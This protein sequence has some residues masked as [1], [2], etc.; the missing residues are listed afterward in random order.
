MTLVSEVPSEITVGAQ[1]I[2]VNAFSFTLGIKNG[3]FDNAKS[4]LVMLLTP[5]QNSNSAK[6]SLTSA[7]YTGDKFL[8]DVNAPVKF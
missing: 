8:I 4:E 3:F 2:P 6:A 5:V 1:S 7:I